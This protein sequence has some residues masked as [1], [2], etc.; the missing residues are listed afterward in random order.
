MA[1]ANQLSKFL[2]GRLACEAHERCCYTGFA[3]QPTPAQHV[4]RAL[5]EQSLCRLPVR[6]FTGLKLVACLAPLDPLPSWLPGRD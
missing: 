4:A 3:D 2:K 6:R 5:R 1:A